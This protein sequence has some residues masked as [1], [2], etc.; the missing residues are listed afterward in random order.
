MAKKA[1][2][3]RPGR[4]ADQFIVRL[5]DGMRDRIAN[6]SRHKGRSMN[7]EIVDALEKHLDNDV[8]ASELWAKVERLES[9]VQALDEP[10][11]PLN[12]SDLK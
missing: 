2:S 1:T 10:I 12:Y 8:S 4:G 9:K 11:N 3:K 7:T 6:L 5:P